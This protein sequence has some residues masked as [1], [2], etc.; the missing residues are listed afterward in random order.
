[1]N[2]L[3]LFDGMSCGRLALE[4]AQIEVTNYYCSEISKGSIKAGKNYFPD[5][6]Y[7][8]DVTKICGNDYDVD[9]LIGGS[10]CQGFSNMGNRLNFDD[11]RSGLILDYFRIFE[12]CN[13]KYFLLENVPMD[14]NCEIE[15]S[16]RLNIL[17]VKIN[18]A[19]SSAQNRIRLY[20]TNIPGAGENLFGNMIDQPEDKEIYLRD[21]LQPESEVDEKYYLKK[22]ILNHVIKKVLEGEK[23]CNL[24]PEKSRTLQAKYNSSWNGTFVSNELFNIYDSGGAAGRVYS[25]DGKSCTLKS[26]GGGGGA[27]TGL[28][29]IPDDLLLSSDQ[30]IN[31]SKD[32]QLIT[33]L[34]SMR[35]RKLTP[36]ECC[37][38]QTVP[39]NFFKGSGISENQQYSC[40]GDGWTIDVIC[41]IL[42]GIKGDFL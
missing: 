8:G 24:N 17:P 10:P 32:K 40:L 3:S 6:K 37:R 42:E 26:R 31:N 33:Y 36:T 41:H 38:L 1:M 23:Y 28:Y 18:S 16:K 34:K 30:F 5:N 2:V 12:E 39:D 9:L 25:V 21:I 19:L 14:K 13:P 22:H 7:I 15:I 20:W 4:R 11:P 29:L 27:K 35:I